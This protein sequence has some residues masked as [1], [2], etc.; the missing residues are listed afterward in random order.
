MTSD[1]RC[2]ARGETR[3]E[4]ECR[5]KGRLNLKGT[6]F[7]DDCPPQVLLINAEKRIYKYAGVCVCCVLCVGWGE[8][9]SDAHLSVRADLGRVECLANLLNKLLLVSLVHWVRAR[10]PAQIE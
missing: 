3:Y 9:G 5:K 2:S 7:N 10:Q 6:R 4:C 1:V 8:F